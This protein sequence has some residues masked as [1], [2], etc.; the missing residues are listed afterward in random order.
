MNKEQKEK[1]LMAMKIH[2]NEQMPKLKEDQKLK[3]KIVLENGDLKIHSR[4]V[5]KDAK[6]S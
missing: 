3:V 5:P 2:I 6:S 4:P 1:F